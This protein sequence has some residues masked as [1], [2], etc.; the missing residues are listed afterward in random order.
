L[1]VDGKFISLFASGADQ[2]SDPKVLL[3]VE[4]DRQNLRLVAML[5]KKLELSGLTNLDQQPIELGPIGPGGIVIGAKQQSLQQMMSKSIF[6]KE[7]K[8]VILEFPCSSKGS[9]PIGQRLLSAAVASLPVGMRR[10]RSRIWHRSQ[11]RW[12]PRHDLGRSG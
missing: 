12:E 4:I 6:G 7:E 2:I 5:I 8:P 1:I 9:I 11:L 3:N 10:R